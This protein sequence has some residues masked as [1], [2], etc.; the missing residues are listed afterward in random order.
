MIALGKL[1]AIFNLGDMMDYNKT[2]FGWTGIQNKKPWAIEKEE[3]RICFGNPGYSVEWVYE[4][5]HDT[6]EEAKKEL[7]RLQSFCDPLSKRS[8]RVINTKAYL[9]NVK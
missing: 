7:D 3:R 2:N 9:Y 1:R 8:Y 6:E 5:F 4:S